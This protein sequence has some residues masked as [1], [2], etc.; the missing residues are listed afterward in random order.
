MGSGR[1]VNDE[2][3]LKGTYLHVIAELLSRHVISVRLFLWDPLPRKK[4]S[5]CSISPVMSRHDNLMIHLARK[6]ITL[7][8]SSVHWRDQSDPW[9][10]WRLGKLF[11]LFQRWAS[12]TI[13]ASKRV[14]RSHVVGWYNWKRTCWTSQ[15]ARRG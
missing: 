2:E 11:G 13:T 8:M 4:L 1:G 10:T 12:S 7:N 14:W 6:Y 5:D 15:C 3:I 9:R